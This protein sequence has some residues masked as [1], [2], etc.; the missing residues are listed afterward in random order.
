[1]G[2]AR[3]SPSLPE[4]LRQTLILAYHQDLKY[5]EIAEILKIP[6]GTV[7]SRLHA[8]LAKLQEMARGHG[9][10]RERS[11]PMNANDLLD[12]SLGQARPRASRGRSTARSPTT[13]GA[14]AALERLG[15]DLD[16][17]LDDGLGE[18]EPPPG[19]ARRTVARRGGQQA[20]AVDPGTSSRSASLSAGPTSPWPPASSRRAC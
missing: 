11:D 10:R 20:P 4:T 1:M 8:A 17:L 18:V 2:P 16:R 12:M 6:V 14:S 13:P 5:R 15:A 9:P 19:L 3:A 7:K